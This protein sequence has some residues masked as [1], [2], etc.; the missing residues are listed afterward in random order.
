MSPHSVP[1]EM[2][3]QHEYTV[4]PQPFTGKAIAVTGAS[5]SVGLALTKYLLARGAVVSICATSKENLDKAVAEIENLNF[6][7]VK[8]RYMTCVVDISK[9]DTVKNCTDSTV[10]KFGKLDG[11]AN[12]AG[13]YPPIQPAILYYY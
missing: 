8:D 2:T 5:R 11:C 6:L 1:V 9:L 4:N 3:G 7:D 13:K 12:V 10:A